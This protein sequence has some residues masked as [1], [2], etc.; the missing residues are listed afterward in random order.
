MNEQYY[1]LLSSYYKSNSFFKANLTYF[2]NYVSNLE[3]A[4]LTTVRNTR[5]KGRMNNKKSKSH[6]SLTR[7]ISC[8]YCE[9]RLNKWEEERQLIIGVCVSERGPS[10]SLFLFN[11]CF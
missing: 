7:T 4:L 11:K 2:D 5:N 9:L 10:L 3:Y 1:T 8:P 6:L